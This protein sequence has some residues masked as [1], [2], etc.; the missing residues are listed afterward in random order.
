MDNALEIRGQLQTHDLFESFKVQLKKD[1]DECAC[2]SSFVDSLQPSFE[3]IK[4]LLTAAIKQSEKKSNFNL[5]QLL[6]RVD[7]N[8]KRLSSELK[9]HKDEDYI[10]VISTLIIKRILQKIVLKKHFSPNGNQDR[11]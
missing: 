3:E 7:I 5:Q 11:I 10:S 1:L 2:D 8:E 6:Y 9:E 4:R